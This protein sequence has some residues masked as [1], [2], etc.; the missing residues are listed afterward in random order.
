[1]QSTKSWVVRYLK[2]HETVKFSLLLRF[3]RDMDSF[4]DIVWR[5]YG[6]C[7]VSA[8]FNWKSYGARAMSARRYDF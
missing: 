1:M 5:S 7:R 2:K 8:L 6:N 4:T 3:V